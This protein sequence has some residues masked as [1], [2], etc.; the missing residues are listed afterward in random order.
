MMPPPLP[1]FCRSSKFDTVTPKTVIP[2][3]PPAC[4]SPAQRRKQARAAS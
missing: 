2:K 1:S 3:P 4:F